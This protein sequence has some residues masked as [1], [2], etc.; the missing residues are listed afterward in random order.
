M[1][2]NKY[3][4]IVLVLI[5][6][7]ILSI[8]LV[9]MCEFKTITRSSVQ[10]YYEPEQFDI[11]EPE[12]KEINKKFNKKYSTLIT[13]NLILELFEP[14]EIYIPIDNIKKDIFLYQN[15]ETIFVKSG[16]SYK[17]ANK[18]KIEAFYYDEPYEIFMKKLNK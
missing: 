13:E 15:E 8:V 12:V 3:L 4:L 14:Y 6:S 5:I 10:H 17:T 11:L 7:I 2:E 1:F 9:L 16:V 18:A